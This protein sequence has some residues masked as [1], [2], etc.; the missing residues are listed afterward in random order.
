MQRIDVFNGDADGIC[1]L[2]QLRLADPA[3]TVLVT[4]PKRDI[5]LV[6][7][8]DAQAGD[9]VTVLDVSLDRNRAAL[10]GLLA[11]G[12]RVRWFD[13]HF[14]GAIP[15]HPLFEPHIE[16]AA[17]VCTSLLVDRHVAGRYRAWA[18]VAAFG[19][20]LTQEA[21][22]QAIPLG[23]DGPS[24]DRL[25]DLGESMNYAAYGETEADLLIPPAELYRLISPYANPLEFIAHER[26]AAQLD[27][28]RHA[29][30]AAAAAVP[31]HRASK[32][33]AIYLLPDKPWARRV[34]GAFANRL[35]AADRYRAYAVAVPN[36]QGGYTV[37]VRAPGAGPRSADA[38]CRDYPTGGG[39]AA[40]AGI[41]HL[42]PE[43]LEEFI[44][45]LE[46]SAI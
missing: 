2:H 41:D 40:A 9:E 17:D 23:L 12:V 26:V 22:A 13:H 46:V 35:A 18:V 29:D 25:R 4:G 10:E 14:P 34:I 31:P 43:R 28:G 19:D 8:V 16:T 36:S 42:P 30:L 33:S 11:R 20:N 5:A 32:F 45:R 1:A 37:S 24:L 39:R 44:A 7:R 15:S 27:E 21:E 6:A 3:D 38:L